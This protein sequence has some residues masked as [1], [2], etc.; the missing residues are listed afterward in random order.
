MRRRGYSRDT[1]P[2]ARLLSIDLFEDRQSGR[3]LI[4]RLPARNLYTVSLCYIVRSFPQR[5][6]AAKTDFVLKPS[7]RLESRTSQ[8][9]GLAPRSSNPSN[10][11]GKPLFLTCSVF[12]TYSSLR[13][14]GRNSAYDS[15]NNPPCSLFAAAYS[16]RRVPSCKQ[17]ADQIFSAIQRDRPHV[18]HRP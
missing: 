11:G 10:S 4:S 12:L 16:A 9:E 14:C 17:S 1:H 8:E 15:Q 13:L 7:L 5:R 18:L 3:R 2:R 6:K